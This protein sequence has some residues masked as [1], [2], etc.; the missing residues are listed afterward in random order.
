MCR[1]ITELRGLDPPAT[2]VEVE[3]AA[4]QFVRKISGVTKPTGAAIEAC[5]AAV[6]EITRTLTMLLE[7][8]PARRQP[9]T[10][11]PP[12][13]RIARRTESNHTTS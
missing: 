9:P 12:I 11:E 7:Q 3:A 13:R 2:P 10:T 1:N 8:L 6:T 4:R 5:D